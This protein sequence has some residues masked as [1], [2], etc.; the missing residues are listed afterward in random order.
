MANKVSKLEREIAFLESDIQHD[1]KKLADHPEKHL[2]DTTFFAAYESK[3]KDL[4][5]LM[6][7][8]ELAVMELDS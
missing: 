1:E 7:Q 4:Q 3:K 8:W 2:H 5:K 6:E